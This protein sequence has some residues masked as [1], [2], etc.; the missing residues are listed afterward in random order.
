MTLFIQGKDSEI[1]YLQ[2]SQ[3]KDRDRD[4]FYFIN[5]KFFNLERKQIEKKNTHI[6]SEIK[7]NTNKY[8]SYYT[9]FSINANSQKYHPDPQIPNIHSKK[10]SQNI[11]NYNP[12]KL[13]G[14][15][16]NSNSTRN[17]I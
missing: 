5:K 13:Q 2:Q 17:K 8:N 9:N 1:K 7:E 4:S 6:I 10:N 12:R 15:T 11:Q 14:N 3:L 16:I